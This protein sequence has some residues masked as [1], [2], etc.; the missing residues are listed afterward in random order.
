VATRNGWIVTAATAIVISSVLLAGIG[1]LLPLYVPF[2]RPVR[3]WSGWALF[4]VAFT[5]LLSVN[6][7][8]HFA[9]GIAATRLCYN[10]TDHTAQVAALLAEG[11]ESPHTDDGDGEEPEQRYA[12]VGRP[13]DG[14][15]WCAACEAAGHAPIAPPRSRHCRACGR[16]VLRMDHHCIFFN[17]CIGSANHRHFVLFVSYTAVACGYLAVM[18]LWTLHARVGRNPVYW[19]D[20]LAVLFPPQPVAP[21]ASASGARRR[22]RRDAGAGGG[23]GGGG[24]GM[25][26]SAG[27][28]GFVMGGGSSGDVEVSGKLMLMS[29]GMPLMLVGALHSRSYYPDGEYTTALTALALLEIAL[30]VLVFTAA[31]AAAQF[32]NLARGVTYVESVRGG[33]PAGARAQ[34]VVQNVRELIGPRALDATLWLVLP[35]YDGARSRRRDASKKVS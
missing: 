4:H 25:A 21:V 16:C 35:R 13:L 24:L 33:A 27:L 1:M 20:R 14:W 9:C 23:G 22:R 8:A 10:A 28:G 11:A 6:V 3:E 29:A 5:A 30:P 26:G 15:R 18:A 19:R 7:S 31:L 12:A 17:G 2:D 32:A 34:T